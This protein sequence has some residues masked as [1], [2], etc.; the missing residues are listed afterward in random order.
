M[1]RWPARRD[2]VSSSLPTFRLVDAS[3][4][5][6][7]M[8]RLAN[9]TAHDLGDGLQFLDGR[10]PDDLRWDAVT[11]EAA[12]ALHPAIRPSILMHGRMVQAPR[13]TQAYGQDYRF[14]GQTSHAEPVPPLIAPHL[15][16]ARNEVHPALNA[17]LVNWYEGPG[18]Y[19][20]P[21]HDTTRWMRPGA[22]IVTMSFGEERVFRLSRGTGERRETRDFRAADGTVFVIPRDT[23]DVWKHAV[24]KSARYTGRRISVT[25]RGFRENG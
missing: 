13:W 4:Y 5:D 25:I 10:L 14:S 7:R 16:W 9:F 6:W 19:I 21:H 2:G 20:G 24:P 1:G 12:W 18:H 15:D 3:R 11:F 22:P 17:V 8:P 23:N